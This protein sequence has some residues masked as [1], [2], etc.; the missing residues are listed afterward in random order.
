MRDIALDS[1]EAIASGAWDDLQAHVVFDWRE[2][3]L[4]WRGSLDRPMHVNA[5]AVAALYEIEEL[6]CEETPSLPAD[7]P[8]PVPAE[9]KPAVAPAPPP[10]PAKGAPPPPTGPKAAGKS[11][12]TPP[13]SAPAGAIP[14]SITPVAAKPHAPA[15]LVLIFQVRE[16]AL[17]FLA[18][19]PGGVHARKPAF[20]HGSPDP[21]TLSQEDR[22]ALL[23]LVTL[24][25]KNRFAFDAKHGAFRLEALDTIPRFVSEELPKWREKFTVEGADALKCFVRGVREAGHGGDPFA[26]RSPRR[27]VAGCR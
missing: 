14:A 3:A 5:L 23:R 2:D 15:R 24:T 18:K 27:R 1:N 21:T 25:R 20:G 7:P 16:D 4:H 6:L 22:E 13:S 17:T 19:W 9:A 8:K 10:V 26:G 11:P 12:A